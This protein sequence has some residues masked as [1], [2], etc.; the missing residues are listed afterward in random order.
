M[1]EHISD[2]FVIVSALSMSV[3]PVKVSTW[4]M[5]IENEGRSPYGATEF[6]I[7]DNEGL[8]LDARCSISCIY[9]NFNFEA[10]S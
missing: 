2:I 6:I 1:S 9:I 3:I 7:F 8:F 4:F 5:V 10:I